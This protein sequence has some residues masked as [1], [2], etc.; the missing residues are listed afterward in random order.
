MRRALVMVAALLAIV[1][2]GV[3]LH[4]EG[5]A[6]AA[7][8]AAVEHVASVN[9]LMDDKTPEQ[10]ADRVPST[11]EFLSLPLPLQQRPS[12]LMLRP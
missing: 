10:A 1:F 5:E 3:Q 7:E 12:K 4:A 6:G 8:P 2:T 11:V 9:D